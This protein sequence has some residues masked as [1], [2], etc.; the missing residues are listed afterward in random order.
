MCQNVT[1]LAHCIRA[2]VMRRT[3]AHDR[4]RTV[5]DVSKCPPKSL[6]MKV[7]VEKSSRARAT[8]QSRVYILSAFRIKAARRLYTGLPECTAT[9]DRTRSRAC[10]CH[11]TARPHRWYWAM[12]G[13]MLSLQTSSVYFVREL[14]SFELPKS[15]FAP[16]ICSNFSPS[17]NCQRIRDQAM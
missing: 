1:Q 9:A 7:S 12:P 8:N 6:P 2:E 4:V 16:A 3:T 13:C 10:R 14:F 15:F 11:S 17:L 5:C